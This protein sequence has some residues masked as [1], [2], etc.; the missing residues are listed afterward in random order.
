MNSVAQQIAEH[1]SNRS[2]LQHWYAKI[3]TTPAI[4][5]STMPSKSLEHKIRR[6]RENAPREVPKA[7]LC[8]AVVLALTRPDP[9]GEPLQALK[10]HLGTNWSPM[11]ALQYMSGRRGAMAVEAS[12]REDRVD[13]YLAHLIAKQVCSG[14]S[15]GAVESVL[16]VDLV[17]SHEMAVSAAAGAEEGSAGARPR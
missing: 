7:K 10:K 13:L 5:W 1:G 8:A 12:S 9:L 3:G 4:R 11:L 16:S 2:W 15:P 6:A 14:N 17:K